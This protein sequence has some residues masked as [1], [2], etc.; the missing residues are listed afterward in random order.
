M[1]DHVPI[2]PC[3]IP[4]FTGDLDALEQDKNAITAAA[5]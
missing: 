5:G 2:N 4:Q 3:T 1:T